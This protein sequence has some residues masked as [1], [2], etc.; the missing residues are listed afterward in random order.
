M[1]DGGTQAKSPRPGWGQ[2]NNGQEWGVLCLDVDRALS[3]AQMGTHEQVVMQYVREHSWATATRRKTPGR[4]PD[5]LTVPWRP[6]DLSKL[7]DIPASRLSEAKK[8]L[9]RSRMLVET[10][11][12]LLI[13]KSGDQWVF[14]EGHSRAGQARLS[15]TSLAYAISARPTE[16]GVPVGDE[17]AE[18][19]ADPSNFVVTPERNAS[20]VTVTPQRNA[21]YAPAY[22]E[23]RSTVIP[24]TPQRNLHIE[25]RAEEEFENEEEKREQFACEPAST[26]IPDQGESASV[27]PGCF[28]STNADGSFPGPIEPDG[29]VMARVRSFADRFMLDDSIRRGILESQRHYPSVWFLKA[30]KRLQL[31]GQRFRW[32]LVRTLL[33]D[34][35]KDGGP[36]RGAE[37]DFGD[38]LVP[39]P[40]GSKA[41]RPKPPPPTYLQPIPRGRSQAPTTLNGERKS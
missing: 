3:H 39:L 33:V 19:L 32:G 14:P 41:D 6:G 28:E 20:T 36:N 23:L 31:R 12:G 10:P 26:P 22:S 15:P 11:A 25:E 40:S 4:W 5:A 2:V 37:D 17:E 9:V 29:A 30:L 7:F 27:P 8:N 34:W 13:N 18:K 1:A 16:K 35:H 21:H 24:I 38:D